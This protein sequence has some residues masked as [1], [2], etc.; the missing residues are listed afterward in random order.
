MRDSYYERDTRI[1]DFEER[2]S[3]NNHLNEPRTGMSV[4]ENLWRKLY[5]Q[6][7]KSTRRTGGG[8]AVIAREWILYKKR[9]CQFTK[10]PQWPTGQRGMSD[11]Y[12]FWNAWR[13][14][15]TSSKSQN[16]T[17][18]TLLTCRVAWHWT[19]YQF[20]HPEGKL[21]TMLDYLKNRCSQCS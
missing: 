11:C 16:Y 10:N 8:R 5:S 1:G 3:G 2:D 14:W 9:S 17:Y 7:M 18:M 20:L 13:P 21:F 19:V 4:E 6:S 15:K 12:V